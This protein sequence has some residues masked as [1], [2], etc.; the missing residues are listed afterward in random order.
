[1][2]ASVL[3]N[4]A[5]EDHHR[6][7]IDVSLHYVPNLS[8]SLPIRAKMGNPRWKMRGDMELGRIP[9]PIRRRAGSDVFE[10]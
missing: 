4:N 3:A 2:T 8:D 1:M 6:Q 7:A 5:V 9:Q 10:I